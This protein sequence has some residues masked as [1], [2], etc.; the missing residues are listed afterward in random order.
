MK[1]LQNTNLSSL[2][3]IFMESK[4]LKDAVSNLQEIGYG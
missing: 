4:S 1:L 2:Y 3:I